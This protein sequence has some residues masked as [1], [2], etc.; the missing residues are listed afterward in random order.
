MTSPA[1]FELLAMAEIQYRRQTVYP[2]LARPAR[3]K[4]LLCAAEQAVTRPSALLPWTSVRGERM[5]E[6]ERAA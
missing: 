2:W 1:E 4:R 3:L 5:S 6:R